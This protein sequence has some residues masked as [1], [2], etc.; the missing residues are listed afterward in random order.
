[1]A[2]GQISVLDICPC[3]KRPLLKPT[4]FPSVTGRT[5]RK[6][7]H[8]MAENPGLNGP[9]LMQ[10]LYADNP[11]GGALSRKIISVLVFYARPQL[12]KDG[13]KIDYSVG[14]GGGYRLRK[15]A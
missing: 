6:L 10:L 8:I 15:I 2:R 14:R 11:N 3:C 7:I 5:R 1:M 9:Q 4:T 12:A 13:Y